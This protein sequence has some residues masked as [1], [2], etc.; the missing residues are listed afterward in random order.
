MQQFYHRNDISR[1]APGKR[2]VVIVRSCNGKEKVQKRHLYMSIKDTSNF[3]LTEHPKVKIG[4]TKF[5]YLRPDHVKFSSEIPANV[6][7]CIYH[8]NIILTLGL[9]HKHVQ[10]IPLH[11]KTFAEDCLLSA[12]EACWYGNCDHDKCGFSSTYAKPE[13]SNTPA[14]WMNWQEVNDRI[15]KYQK[16]GSVGSLYSYLC[17]IFP[18]FFI[19]SFVKRKQAKSYVEDKQEALMK[20]SN[21]VMTK[22]DFTENYTCAA[23]DEVQSAYWKQN[24]STLFTSV[25]SFR[26]NTQC[27]VIISDHLKHDKIPIVVFR[28]ELFSKKPANATTV[29]VWSDGP[30][31]QF[32]NKYVMGSLDKLSTKHKVHMIWNFSV[33]SH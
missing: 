9:I 1:M 13:N 17:T 8:Q 5:G 3:F 16:S 22:V 12:D 19:H 2:D 26:E 18:D 23:Q 7:T 14:K 11:S 27:E 33:T 32:K 4:L 31:N 10:E 25:L 24:Q 6:Y 29:K 21:T 30:S 15:I 20:N 28:D